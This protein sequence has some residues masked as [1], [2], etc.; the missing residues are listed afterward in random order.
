MEKEPEKDVEV[1]AKGLF[2]KS[3]EILGAV[4][5]KVKGTKDD[6]ALL[7]DWRESEEVVAGI[8]PREMMAERFIFQRKIN[9]HPGQAALIMS[10]GR[11]VDVIQ[12]GQVI[13]S[14]LIDRARR[15]IGDGED[16]VVMMIVTK[17]LVLRVATGI[18]KYEMLRGDAGLFRKIMNTLKPQAVDPR[19]VHLDD[20]EKV[21][22]L[23]VA[24][25]QVHEGDQEISNLENDAKVQ[26]LLQDLIGREKKD[27]PTPL[28]TKDRESVL[29]D[30]KLLVNFQTERAIE[31]FKLVGSKKS[32]QLRIDDLQEMIGQ[33]LAV[34]VFA[35]RLQ[36]HTA[37]ELRR[38]PEIIS[39][40]QQVA[41][42]ELFQWLRNYG[43][44]LNRLLINPATTDYERIAIITKEKQALE[45]LAT[46]QYERSKAAAVR[47]YELLLL[48]DRHARE[49]ERAKG[50]HDIEKK[51]LEAGV[52]LA[53]MAGKLS[54]QEIEA[55]IQ[56]IQTDTKIE[57]EKKAQELELFGIER[58]WEVDKERRL[59][60]AKIE[61]DKK[62]EEAEIEIAEMKAFYEQVQKIEALKHQQQ[63]EIREDQRK[64][65]GLEIAH[66]QNLIESAIKAG[67]LNADVVTE[68]IRQASVRKALDRGDA[69]GQAFAQAEGQK[70]A[71]E[72]FKEGLTTQPPT[73]LLTN[74]QGDVL[75][76]AGQP[77][78]AEMARGSRPILG[79]KHPGKAP[80][81][82]TI[83]C[84]NP[85]CRRDVPDDSRVCPYCATKLI[86]GEENAQ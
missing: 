84:L 69:T 8:V 77:I 67:I 28:L 76:L 52:L 39:D 38:N 75:F 41:E 60:E 78:P 18:D 81:Q 64:T 66:I 70:Y 16:L 44:Q 24:E 31:I 61:I 48:R 57:G 37:E 32:K 53:D 10:R 68:S 58:Q 82:R 20:S 7:D 63:L 35:T 13:R 47:E 45:E 74:K 11:V 80:E 22:D 25:E 56:R 9:V 79:T 36:Q 49:F 2:D 3:K 46:G 59:T 40:L 17:E 27:S 1:E 19:R 54:A 43:I 51:K 6:G 72:N 86:A 65:I 42:S 30:V 62:R 29:L 26:K 15:M 71:K 50:E 12:T 5:G 33:E 21:R 34:R 23:V 55:Q 85:N 83:E 73:G 4:T 14:G